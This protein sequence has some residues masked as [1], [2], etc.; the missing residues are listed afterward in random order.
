MSRGHDNTTYV[1]TM[2]EKMKTEVEF[3]GDVTEIEGESAADLA[4]GLKDFAKE[5]GLGR[6][7]ARDEDGEKVTE[8]NIDSAE[9]V[10]LLRTEVA[11]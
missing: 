1:I 9:K 4:D 10:K 11:G 7:L 3:E 6:F 2:G 8:D 5:K